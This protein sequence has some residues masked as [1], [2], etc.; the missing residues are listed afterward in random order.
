MRPASVLLIEKIGL[1]GLLM[2]DAGFW[3]VAA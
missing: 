2:Q 1:H 3:Q